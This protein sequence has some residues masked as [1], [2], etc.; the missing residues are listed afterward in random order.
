MKVTLRQLRALVAVAD[1]GSFTAAAR[2]L[3]LTPSALSLLVKELEATLG[4]R[5]FDRSTRRTSLTAAG[6]EFLPL[7]RR[8]L[9]DIGRAVESAHDLQQKKRGSVRI[10]C[11]PLYSATLMPGLIAR[12]HQRY[13]AV[14][15]FV[16][17]SLN[18]QALQRVASGEADFGIAPQRASPP[19]LVQQGLLKDR[20]CLLCAPGHPLAARGNITW[21]R[22]LREPFVS[23][24]QDFTARLQADLFRHSS[25]L[26]LE[27]AHHVSFL[28]TAL[29]MVKVGHGVTAQP[30]HAQ[31]LAS[32]FGLVA[33]PITSPVIYRQLSLF[34]K[35]N[36]S[37]SP[38]AAS[39]RDF[40]L[41]EVERA[42]P[43][44]ASRR[45]PSGD[46][47]S[48]ISCAAFAA[49]SSEGTSNKFTARR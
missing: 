34:C 25:A 44:A 40:L 33:R 47:S 41:E 38:A 23:L 39:F 26:V 30:M 14:R 32:A 20:F 3:S 11:T 8:V 13:P 37:F 49:A 17:D 10:A 42:A 35:R 48:H 16:L 21:A 22:V 29:G 28:T 18:Q 9:E 31:A 24:T 43:P 19:E 15:V 6:E 5:L 4:V 2:A 12:Y 45:P 36:S 46:K 27:P 1:Q 7:A